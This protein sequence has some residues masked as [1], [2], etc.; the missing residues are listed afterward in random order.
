MAH[1]NFKQAML[2]R[3]TFSLADRFKRNIHCIITKR[4]KSMFTAPWQVSIQSNG[5]IG[6]SLS[7]YWNYG[8]KLFSVANR[9]IQTSILCDQRN[10]QCECQQKQ[11]S[12]L[13]SM[14]WTYCSECFWAFVHLNLNFLA[15]NNKKHI[16]IKNIYTLESRKRL[17]LPVTCICNHHIPYF[18]HF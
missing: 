7:T 11:W 15:K 14:T 17:R 3:F 5:Y 13:A 16:L 2:I 4:S 9:C 18:T 6:F 8:G 1:Y 10:N 12:V